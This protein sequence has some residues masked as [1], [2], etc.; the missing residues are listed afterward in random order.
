MLRRDRK[1]RAQ[2]QRPADER[3]YERVAEMDPR[4][5]EGAGRRDEAERAAERWVGS[6]LRRTARLRRVEGRRM[7][8]ARGER[9]EGCRA[10]PPLDDATG[11]VS[12]LRREIDSDRGAER[13]YRSS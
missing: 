11:R 12:R 8:E 2:Q 5:G 13:R 6:D 4:A 9:Q 7:V 10:G 3:R 1:R